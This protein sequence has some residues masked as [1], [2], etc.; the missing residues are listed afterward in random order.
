MVVPRIRWS[1][2]ALIF[3]RS[4]KYDVVEIREKVRKGEHQEQRAVCGFPSLID[5]AGT[6]GSKVTIG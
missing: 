4:S 6:Y 2:C 5:E 1:A 3:L